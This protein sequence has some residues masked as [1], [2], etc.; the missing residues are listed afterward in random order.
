MSKQSGAQSL[1]CNLEAFRSDLHKASELVVWLYRGLD[2]A[3]I[4]S[5]VQ[6]AWRNKIASARCRITKFSPTIKCT[7]SSVVK[8]DGVE[9]MHVW[10]RRT[11]YP[12]GTHDFEAVQPE[13]L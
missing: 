12:P 9:V 8:T 6:I 2:R 11:P 5:R 1:D 3:R 4:T 10:S 13:H 7:P